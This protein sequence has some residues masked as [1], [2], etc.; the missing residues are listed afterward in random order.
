MAIKAFG[1]EFG[2]EPQKETTAIYNAAEGTKR[3]IATEEFNGTVAV[4]AGGVFVTYIDYSTNLKD[5]NANI[6]QYRNMSLYPEVDAAI[7]EI[8]NASI[9]W[10]TDRKPIKIDLTEM[11]LSEQ[12]KRK[13]NSSYDRILKLLDFI[14][15]LS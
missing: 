1:F 15:Y 3:L 4:E 13:I 9:V 2:S 6:I 7:D 14:Y 5:E 11:P 8:V 10:G 12:L